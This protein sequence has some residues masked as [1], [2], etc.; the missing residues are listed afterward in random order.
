V[1]G[2]TPEIGYIYPAPY[3]TLREHDWVKSLLL[4]FDHVA[5]LQP[6]YMY[7]RHYRADPT[8]VGPLKERGLLRTLEPGTWIDAEARIEL[9]NT[10]SHLLNSDAFDALDLDVHLQEPSQSRTG[11][12]VDIDVADELVERLASAGLVEPTKDGVST[13]MHP[14]VRSTILVL[15]GQLARGIGDRRGEVLHPT[16][17]HRQRVDDLARFLLVEQVPPWRR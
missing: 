6:D 1:T 12:G 3:W 14:V 5:I 15:L 2:G 9:T 8:L 7:G 4:F 16:T 11:Y 17:A 13:P 10:I